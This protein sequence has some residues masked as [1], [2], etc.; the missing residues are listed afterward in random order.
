MLIINIIIFSLLI[1]AWLLPN[2]YLPWLSAYQELCMFLV[3]L[4]FIFLLIL[5]NKIYVPKIAYGILLIFLIPIIQFFLGIIHNLGDALLTSMY[6]GFFLIALIGGYS[7]SKLK[8]E[9]RTKILIFFLISFLF[10]SIVSVGLQ[11][12]Q[13]LLL[14]GNIWI[15]DLAPNARPFANVAQPNLLSTL[16]IIGLFSVF[17]FYENN[18]INKFS[19]SLAAI[20]V[21]FGLALNFSRT[22]WVFCIVFIVFYLFKKRTIKD[23]FYLKTLSIFIWSGVFFIYLLLI[24]YLS[25]KLGLLYEVDLNR[26]VTSGME[27]LNMW[28]QLL[29]I[30]QQQPFLGYG[31]NQLNIAQMSVENINLNHPIFGYSHNFVLDL[32]IWNGVLIGVILVGIMGYFYINLS[33][34][35]DQKNDLILLAI[36]GIIVLHSMLEYPFAYSYFLI[37]L[38]FLTG[39]VYG[40][41]YCNHITLKKSK[42]LS[43]ILNIAL[44]GVLFLTAYEYLKIDPEYQ[45]MRYENVQLKD[46]EPGQEEQQYLMLT[47]INDY[48]WFV[49]YPLQSG[50]SD[51]ELQR[52]K[53]VAFKKPGKAV[54]IHYAKLLILNNRVDEAQFVINKYNAFYHSKLKISDL[55]FDITHN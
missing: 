52:A 21:L 11:L 17:Y 34:K 18:K 23:E 39:L 5:K 38:A 29:D 9:N 47:S 30:I 4:L 13:W 46:R 36:I 55:K 37:P 6:I 44:T 25:E 50:M 53:Q 27:R 35:I 24:P 20:F 26:R 54:L 7:I 40:N 22:A 45:A 42:I 12:N 8:H 51:F 16:L 28:S 10:S 33:I 1:L 15:V 49:R 32:L 19:A 41:Y 48:I 43:S 14:D 31:W 3:A 2:H